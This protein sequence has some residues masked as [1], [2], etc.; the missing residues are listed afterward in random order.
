[1][2]LV[3][4]QLGPLLEELFI[5]CGQKF[6][7]KTVLMLAEEMI[8]NIKF[9]Y[10]SNYIYCDI[11]P[12]NFLLDTRSDSTH[13]SI[14]D[15][16]LASK[17]C[18][19]TSQQHIPSCKYQ[20]FTDLEAS[21]KHEKYKCILQ[22]KLDTSPL[23]LCAGLSTEFQLFLKY[24]RALSFTA[25]PDYQYIQQLFSNIFSTNDFQHDDIF[26][27]SLMDIELTSSLGSMPI[28]PPAQNCQLHNPGFIYF[29]LIAQ[30]SVPPRMFRSPDASLHMLASS[31]FTGLFAEMSGDERRVLA[32]WKLFGFVCF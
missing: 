19:S 26:D 31:I 1:M 6:L 18:D 10:R 16:G 24:A 5:L 22:K 3:M 12:D 2:V 11:K 28:L 14:I 30:P 21:T 29:T 27:W 4:D 9:V 23:K 20:F 7:L 17:Y 8:M 15:F 32:D 13:I 25:S